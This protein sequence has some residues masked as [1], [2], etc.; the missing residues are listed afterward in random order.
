MQVVIHD[1]SNSEG[2]RIE[3]ALR[4]RGIPA[5][6]SLDPHRTKSVLEAER[7]D[8]VLLCART[9]SA[10]TLAFAEDLR[11]RLVL[12]PAQLQLVTGPLRDEDVAEVFDAGF[13]AVVPWGSSEAALVSRVAAAERLLDRCERKPDAPAFQAGSEDGAGLP[14]RLVTRSNAWRGAPEALRVVV[15]DF[16][17]HQTQLSELGEDDQPPL[18]RAAVNF[19]TSSAHGVQIRVG[20]GVEE[21]SGAILAAKF[22]GHDGDHLIDDMLTEL[23][24]TLT[25]ALKTHFGLELLPFTPGLPVL[26][27]PRELTRPTTLFVHRHQV[28]FSVGRGRLLLQLGMTSKALFSIDIENL[29]EGLILAQDL[30]G[31]RGELML[32]RG[33]RLSRSMVQKLLDRLPARTRLQVMST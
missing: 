7:A 8:V 30:H 6:V 21:S 20:V 27:A 1:P 18:D 12:E 2:P 16:F 4:G 29:S 17:S 15:A 5:V 32:R 19:L 26:L 13:D 14:Q 23:A 3:R 22:V 9:F 24:N 25:G 11:S 10:D 28:M 33:T 31:A